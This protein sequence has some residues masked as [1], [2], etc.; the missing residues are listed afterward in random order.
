MGIGAALGVPRGKV[1]MGFEVSGS[2]GPQ[3][4]LAGHAG[5]GRLGRRHTVGAPSRWPAVAVPPYALN[6]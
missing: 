1:N 4:D 6:G 2:G 5:R 3:V